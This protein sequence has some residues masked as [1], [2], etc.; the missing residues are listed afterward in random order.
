MEVD[1]LLWLRS[2][3]QIRNPAT[4]GPRTRSHPV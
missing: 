2:D 3:A 4:A 1:C